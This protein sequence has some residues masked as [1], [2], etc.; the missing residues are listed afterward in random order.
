MNCP[1]FEDALFEYCEG[2]A[3]PAEI[4]RVESHLAGCAGCRAFLE[5]QQELDRKLTRSLPRPALSPAFGPRL[6]GRLAVA[7]H[8][9]W[10]RRF[11][12]VLDSV[13]YLSLA[14]LCGRLIEQLP[15]AGAWLA[16][17]A[18][19]GSVVFSLWE[20]GKALRGNYGHR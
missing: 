6:A 11:P 2:G 18:S 15:H 1:E 7:R 4:A 3:A 14:F 16:L 20:T 13:G 5:T 9:P 12:L 17:A 10:F 19:A 8:G